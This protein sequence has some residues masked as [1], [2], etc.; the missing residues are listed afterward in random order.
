MTSIT[1][2]AGFVVFASGAWLVGLAIASAF[3]PRRA[4]AFLSGFASSAR[5]HVI[6]QL[7]RIVAGTGFVLYADHLRFTPAFTVFGW[8]L[9][10]TSTALLFIP[11]RWHRRFAEQVVPIAVRH[12]KLY[13]A[14]ALALGLCIFYAM[15]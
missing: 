3:A 12:I 6:E 4:A 2:L 13:A 8:V 1:G 11:W 5:T 7:I 10:G 9:I 15:L 14:A